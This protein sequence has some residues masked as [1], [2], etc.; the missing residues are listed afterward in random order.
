MTGFNLADFGKELLSGFVMG[1]LSSAAFYGAGKTVEVVKGR[2]RGAGKGSGE[3]EIARVQ[4]FRKTQQS[5]IT[6]VIAGVDIRTGNVYVGVKNSS[7]YK[8]NTTCV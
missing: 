2:V 7:V 8:T 4:G 3:A 1:G 5:N 6:T